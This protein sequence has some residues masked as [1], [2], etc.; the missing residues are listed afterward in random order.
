MRHL[1]RKG[2]FFYHL[3]ANYLKRIKMEK[4]AK[5]FSDYFVIYINLFYR[6]KCKHEAY[7]HGG[8][9]K[10]MMR[11]TKFL[12]INKINYLWRSEST[13]SN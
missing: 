11:K 13:R 5:D 1:T 3:L 12:K 10:N 8:S 6:Q 4:N 7:N 2:F 9:N